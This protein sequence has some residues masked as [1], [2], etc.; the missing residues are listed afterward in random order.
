M[1][2]PTESEISKVME[3]RKISRVSAIQFIRRQSAKSAILAGAQAKAT[4]PEP[5]KATPAKPKA[6]K[7]KKERKAAVPYEKRHAAGV[8]VKCPRPAPKEGTVCAYCRAMA[9]Y[10]AECKADKRPFTRE[11][12]A[13]TNAAQEAEKL[14]AKG[15]LPVKA[16]VEAKSAAKK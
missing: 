15:E 10:Y 13:R 5:A 12:F 1:A 8:C 6:D 11:N 4:K 14:A 7:P 3:D 9:T 2:Y 16:K